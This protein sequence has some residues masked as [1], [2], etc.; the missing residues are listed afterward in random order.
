M[1]SHNQRSAANN[2]PRSSSPLPARRAVRNQPALSSP[3]P[4]R[5]RIKVRVLIQRA[6][7]ARDSRFRFCSVP[8]RRLCKAL[9]QGRMKVRILVQ[10]A[11]RAIRDSAAALWWRRGFVT[12]LASSLLLLPLS[13][14]A[15]G[16]DGHKIVAVIAAD[17]LTPAAATHVATILGVPAD[18]R[19]VA[20][21]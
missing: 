13:A 6:S 14:H 2:Q 10:R 18:K 12:S 17:N 11:P 19:S 1:Q 20:A 3:L 9:L 4:E 8:M 16:T 15:W 7:F 21:S 5:E